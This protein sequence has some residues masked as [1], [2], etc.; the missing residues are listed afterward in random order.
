MN[1]TRA[2]SGGLVFLTGARTRPTGEELLRCS[3]VPPANRF[4]TAVSRYSARTK[5][6]GV[7]LAASFHPTAGRFQNRSLRDD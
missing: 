7:P 6:A 5:D 4:Q 1:A 3:V 2:E